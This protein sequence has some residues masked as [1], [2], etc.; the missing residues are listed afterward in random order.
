MGSD[1]RS[2]IEEATIKGLTP[3]LGLLGSGGAIFQELCAGCI[4]AS[5]T[6]TRSA[7]RTAPVAVARRSAWRVDSLLVADSTFSG[8]TATTAGAIEIYGNSTFSIIIT[9]DRCTFT[10]NT[11]TF[12]GGAIAVESLNAG[13]SVNITN[14]TFTGNTASGANG[15]GAA[16]YIDA[17]PVTITN[18][19]IAGNTAG[20]SGGALYFG[21]RTPVTAVT[22]TIIASNSGGNCSFAP[23]GTFA[24][25]HDLQFGDTTCT[26]MTV[27]K[28]TP[29]IPRQQ[30]R[31][32]T[33]YGPR[34]QSR[35]RWGR[36]HQR[37]VDRSARRDP[38]GRQWRRSHRV[39][40]GAFETPAVTS[41]N[42]NQASRRHRAVKP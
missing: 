33:D 19:T 24:V 4:P 1:L 6:V 16:I 12:G 29:R 3:S 41:G 38:D 26:G 27:A 30:R 21:S 11:A 17:A 23:G 15:Q 13:S 37:T 36:H 35:H 7:S 40:I 31:A 2:L 8:N 5:L 34:R 25:G 14:G 9:I 32:D 39:D 20:T 18:C 10:G 22:N 28:C 42:G